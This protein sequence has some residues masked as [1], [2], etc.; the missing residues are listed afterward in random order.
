MKQD[1][2]YLKGYLAALRWVRRSIPIP[3]DV[4]FEIGKKEKVVQ[5]K[6]KMLNSK[7]K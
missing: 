4:F 6:V 1:E 3:F 5:T 2:Q 7:K